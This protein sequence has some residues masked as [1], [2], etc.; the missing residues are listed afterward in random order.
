MS[1]NARHSSVLQ[2]L[3]AR[4][5]QMDRSRGV[6]KGAGALSSTGVAALDT[7]LP[8][9]AFRA[10]MIVEW[11]V[12][13]AG[14]GAARLA[15]PMVLEALT[16][17][18]ERVASRCGRSPDR[19]TGPDR[20]SPCDSTERVA[21]ALVVIDERR[22]FYPPAAACLGLDLNRMI[23]VRPRNHQETIWPSNRRS[24]VRGSLP[25]WAGSTKSLTVSS[26]GFNWLRNTERGWG[27]SCGRPRRGANRPGPT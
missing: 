8:P 1:P 27:C 18:E 4:L 19:A 11:I 5:R 15:L 9:G 6:S 10:G 17:P 16:R 13:G 23:V 26:G 24:P 2:D 12:E 3:R 22:E 21:G 14:S 25:R 7:L 20:R